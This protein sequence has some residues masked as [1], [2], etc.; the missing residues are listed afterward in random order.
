MTKKGSHHS[1]KTKELLRAISKA[2]KMTPEQEANRLAA[3]RSESNREKLRAANI[4]KVLSE[5]H[6]RK[7]S[8]SHKGITHTEESKQKMRLALKGRKHTEGTISLMKQI[9][10]SPEFKLKLKNILNTPE[11]KA[12]MSLAQKGKI[13][14]YETRQLQ[15]A[16]K[17]G[18]PFPKWGWEKAIA[19]NTGRTKIIKD[20]SIIKMVET[21]LGGF[22]MGNVRYQK[23]PVYC[24]LW[25]DVNPRVHAFFE[26]KCCLCGVNENGKSHIGHHV[27]YVKETC[28]WHDENGEYYTNLNARDHKENDYF[29]GGNPNYFVILC[30]SCHAKTNGNFKN[31]KRWADYFKGLIENTYSGKCYFTPEEMR[32]FYP[33]S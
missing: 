29:I 14:S 15:S 6:K 4:G 28:C 22:W 18:K 25:K 31:R 23:T 2:Y 19:H 21:K 3:I 20:E 16:A 9:H 12:K 5:D 8:E 33:T 1:E 17:K 26:G 13:V 24:E 32:A 7:I 30:R 10:N 11:C 27:F